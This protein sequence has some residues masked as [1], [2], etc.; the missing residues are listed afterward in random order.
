MYALT[1]IIKEEKAIHL[2]VLEAWEGLEGG[3]E[4]ES[5][6]IL[7]QLK[8]IKNKWNIFCLFKKEKL[9]SR[10]IMT[11]NKIVYAQ[12]LAPSCHSQCSVNV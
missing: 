10:A 5:D 12:Y 6:V 1:I 4:A 9:L 2:R 11:S 8:R 7:F 3:K